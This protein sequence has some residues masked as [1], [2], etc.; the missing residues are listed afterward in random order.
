M[1]HQLIDT[2]AAED[3]IDRRRDSR[4]VAV[5]VAVSGIYATLRYNVFK[6]VPWSDWP[7]YVGNKILALSALILVS[8]R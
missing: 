8:L 1:I 6:R 4:I 7:H 3:V 2:K 5:T